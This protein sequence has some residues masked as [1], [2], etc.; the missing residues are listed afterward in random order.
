MWRKPLFICNSRDHVQALQR[1]TGSSVHV[2]FV[3]FG[4]ACVNSLLSAGSG[5]AHFLWPEGLKVIW[6]LLERRATPLAWD[7]VLFYSTSHVAL[8]LF[9]LA[10][11]R[12]PHQPFFRGASS[13]GRQWWPVRKWERPSS[14]PHAEL[15]SFITDKRT[16]EI[17]LGSRQSTCQTALALLFSQHLDAEP[18]WRI[19]FICPETDPQAL[20]QLPGLF[21][22]GW[23][24][25][26]AG[27]HVFTH[28][29]W[30]QPVQVI[31]HQALG[32]MSL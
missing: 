26:S 9:P 14:P 28:G 23:T 11:A 3:Q 22:W 31:N 7:Y 27:P 24:G 30:K 19:C 16:K 29:L 21:F 20:V 13:I 18:K 1:H 10:E 12:L 17:F 2:T 32:L 8:L 5:W 25:Q 4:V 15:T 6:S